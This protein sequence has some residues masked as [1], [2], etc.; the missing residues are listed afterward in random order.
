MP[1][2]VVL[3][4]MDGT[5]ADFDGQML[6]DLRRMMSPGEMDTPAGPLA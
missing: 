4:D 1:E 2:A 5:L 6:S 3:I